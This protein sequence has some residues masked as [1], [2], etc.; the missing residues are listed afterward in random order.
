MIKKLENFWYHYRPHTIAGFFVLFV[1]IYA[2]FNFITNV[3]YDQR[4]ILYVSDTVPL[5]YTSELA[6][7][8]ETYAYGSNNNKIKIN[9]ADFSYEKANNNAKTKQKN[10]LINQIASREAFIFIT[11]ETCF[12]ELDQLD[13]FESNEI[14]NTK[15]GKA[16]ILK[17]SELIQCV[18]NKNER[19]KKFNKDNDLYLSIRKSSSL[20]E[21]ERKLYE[22]AL[23]LIEKIK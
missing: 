14:F 10:A 21:K 16:M 5:D 19:F 17:N 2:I 11:D 23:S 3:T 4:I 20:N 7:L 6:D 12:D 18:S 22:K 15:N 1:V 9:V 8:L 13:L